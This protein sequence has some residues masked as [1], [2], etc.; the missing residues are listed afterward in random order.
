LPTR[1]RWSVRNSEIRFNG[2]GHSTPKARMDKGIQRGEIDRLVGMLGRQHGS[3]VGLTF[4]LVLP[5]T[6]VFVVLIPSFS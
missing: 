3:Y 6:D 4:H 2:C 5:L 1:R